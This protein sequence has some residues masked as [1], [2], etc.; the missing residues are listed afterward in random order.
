MDELY[1]PFPSGL[2][3]ETEHAHR[4]TSEWARRFELIN[5][6][7]S[8]WQLEH[9]QFSWLVGR[10]F[11]FA[12]RRELQLISDFT[13]WLFWHDDLCDET[14][15]GKDPRALGSRFDQLASTFA[16][17]S[18]PHPGHAFDLALADLRD[19]FESA[20]PSVAWLS[21]FASSMRDY[22]DACVWEASNRDSGAKPSTNVFICMRRKASGMCMY[23][24]FLE[25][26]AQKELPLVVRAHRDVQRL[27]RI[28]NNVASWHNDL[29]SIAKEQAQGD[30]HN[31]ALALAHEQQLDVAAAKRLTV[32]LCNKEVATFEAL[33]SALPAFEPE[34]DQDLRVF[35]AALGSMMR[36]NLDWS[37]ATQRYGGGVNAVRA[38]VTA[39]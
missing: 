38:A 17:R 30:V 7:D 24:D 39:A 26:I 2:N 9:S 28:T 8:E 15:L 6:A 3:P 22:F 14:S 29:F 25:L 16:R 1:C 21:R 20:A 23:V 4:E 11:P 27:A 37:L 19:R 13:S 33:R 35:V 12:A 10:F 18:S 36:G 5:S 34:V 31:L 32:A